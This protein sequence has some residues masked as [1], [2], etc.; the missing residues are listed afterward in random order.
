[1][2]LALPPKQPRLEARLTLEQKE[3]L[4]HAAAL[5]GTSLTDFVVRSAQRAAEQSIREHS[6]LALTV[7]ESYDFVESL[8]NPPRPSETL[9][10]AAEH[11]KRVAV[12]H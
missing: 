10:A 3:L 4:Q 5:E 7:R 12:R 6:R 2:A 11:Y 8:L 9:R 1:M